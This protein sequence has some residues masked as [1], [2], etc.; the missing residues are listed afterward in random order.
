[1]TDL[2][3]LYSGDREQAIV[4]YL[5]GEHADFDSAER[6]AFD[7]HVSTCARCRAELSAFESVRASLGRWAPPSLRSEH[8]PDLGA[9]SPRTLAFGPRSRWRDIPA[10]AQVAAALLFL[11]ASAG[12]AN[13]D[14]RY[15]ASGLRV[16]TGWSAAPA[17]VA[18]GG[19]PV[20]APW[21]ADLAGLE[22][23][24][25]SDLRP[26]APLVT[27]AANPGNAPNQETLSRVRAL[28]GESERRQE[29][30]LALRLGEVMR[31]VNAQRQADLVKIDRNIGAMQNT[32]GREMLRQRSEML[33]YLAVRASSQRPQ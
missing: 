23:R 31:D 32:T 13:L 10:W 18:E 27:Q 21:R 29:R 17:P 28:L 8:S 2:M 1:M 3:C 15:D 11:G 30:E 5:Y 33:N 19:R 16:R 24:L 9:A 20:D 22:Q 6:A 25:R 26:P 12:I 4:S 14:V 7:M